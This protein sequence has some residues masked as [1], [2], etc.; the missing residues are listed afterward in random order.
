M[1]NNLSIFFTF[2]YLFSFLISCNESKQKDRDEHAKLPV[3]PVFQPINNLNFDLS[4]Q[5]KNN[6]DSGTYE[7][8]FQSFSKYYSRDTA[9]IFCFRGNAQRNSPTR[10]LI[11]GRPTDIEEIWTFATGYDTTTTEYGTWGGGSGWTGQPL[12]YLL[13]PLEQEKRSF[14]LSL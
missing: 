1:K 7:S 6:F 12:A 13:E 8:N 4:F 5:T 11:S 3:N 14:L 10:G 9:S 2:I